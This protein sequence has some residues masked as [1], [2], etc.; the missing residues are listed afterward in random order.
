MK[1][2]SKYALVFVG[3]TLAFLAAAAAQGYNILGLVP[4]LVIIGLILATTPWYIE[5]LKN[6]SPTII[7]PTLGKLNCASVDPL[8]ATAGGPRAPGEALYA[9]G[10]IANEF[11]FAD[12]G[13]AW[14]DGGYVLGP[15]WMAIRLGKNLT[16]YSGIPHEVRG[17][18][19]YPDWARAAIGDRWDPIHTR[20]YVSFFSILQPEATPE[21][22]AIAEM[23]T[24]AQ[25]Q[26]SDAR[27]MAD[28]TLRV[29]RQGIEA[30]EMIR[31]G[32]LR[33]RVREAAV[34]QKAA[35]EEQQND[36]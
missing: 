8:A 6:G 29:I 30:Q 24:S 21:R 15:R 23:Y 35:E 33:E 5:K 10:G 3:F 17:I 26:R 31:R 28:D 2:S 19:M 7:I 20:F 32:P 27:N 11:H 9:F 22:M 4:W 12:G 25:G 1:R 14:L 16:Y 34:R 18:D 36:R 13:S